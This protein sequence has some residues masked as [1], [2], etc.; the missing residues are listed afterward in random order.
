MACL[1]H[2]SLWAHTLSPASLGSTSSVQEHG[3]RLQV[4]SGTIYTLHP[5]TPGPVQP[6]QGPHCDCSILYNELSG[7]S[8]QGEPAWVVVLLVGLFLSLSRMTSPIKG[9]V[10]LLKRAGVGRTDAGSLN[11]SKACHTKGIFDAHTG[12]T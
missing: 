7:P 12:S 5:L 3:A 11:L 2:P 8:G 10:D 9:R 1:A 6:R 4:V